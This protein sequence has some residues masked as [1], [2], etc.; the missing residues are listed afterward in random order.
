MLDKKQFIRKD[1]AARKKHISKETVIWLSQKICDS[2]V[3]TD[4]FQKANQ[5]A[6]YYAMND[7]V[8]TSGLIEEWWTKKNI[9]LPV[10]CGEYINFYAYTGKE[11]LIKSALGIP[12]PAPTSV[13]PTEDIDLF[14]VPGIA[15]DHEGH[16]LGRGKGYYDRYLAGITKPIIGICFD[17]QLID[18][19]PAEKHD[20][21]MN[22]IITENIIVSS[23]H[24]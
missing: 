3:Q 13:I 11:N 6:L 17:F 7:E 16:R 19:V 10:V 21:K 23:H 4:I 2:L 9:A 5:I 24:Q 12:E 15:F 18:S 8:Q 22:T 14:V 1:I 20:I